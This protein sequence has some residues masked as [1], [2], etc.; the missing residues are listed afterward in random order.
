MNMKKNITTEKMQ[1]VLPLIERIELDN[2]ISLQLQ[3]LNPSGESTD[4][5]WSSN[6]TFNNDPYKGNLA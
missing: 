4:P 3:S 2:D 1:Y 6:D 5:E